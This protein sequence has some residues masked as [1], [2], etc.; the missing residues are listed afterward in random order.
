MVKFECN[1]CGKCCRSFGEFIRIERQLTSRDYYCRYGITN[2]LFLVHVQPEFAEEISADLDGRETLSGSSSQRGCIFSR[3]NQ[4]GPGFL[5]AVYPTRPAICREFRCYRMLIHHA[6]SGELRG[7]VLGINELK[8][9][10]PDLVRLWTEKVSEIPH[11][12]HGRHGKVQHSPG[13]GVQAA[14]G[15]DAYIL[16]HIHDPHPADDQGW[17]KDV[18]SLLASHGYR[19]DPVED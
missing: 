2:E 1:G 6:G 14:H 12:V 19:G 15:H 5:C 9:E 7:R 3:K 4:S 18:I 10:D 16:A 17:I 11:P 13:S 8:S